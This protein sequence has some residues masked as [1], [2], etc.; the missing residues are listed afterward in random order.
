MRMNGNAVLKRTIFFLSLGFL[1][2]LMVPN[3]LAGEYDNALKGVKGIDVIYD[4]STA[5]PAFNNVVFWAVRDVYQNEV[6]TSLPLTVPVLT[7]KPSLRSTSSRLPCE[8]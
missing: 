3:A 1:S 5:D 2:L 4:V 6:V 8:K 7:R